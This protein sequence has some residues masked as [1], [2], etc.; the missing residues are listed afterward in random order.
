MSQAVRQVSTIAA[1]LTSGRGVVTIVAGALNK[2]HNWK[3]LHLYSAIQSVWKVTTWCWGQGTPNNMEIFFQ[4]FIK[5]QGNANLSQ[6]T[7]P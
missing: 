1:G 4:R 3:G 7:C 5:E 2:K 6:D